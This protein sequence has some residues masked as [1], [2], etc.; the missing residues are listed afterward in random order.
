MENS[1]TESQ[2]NILV[3]VRDNAGKLP[4]TSGGNLAE[5]NLKRSVETLK[6]NGFLTPASRNGV[7]VSAKGIAALKAIEEADNTPE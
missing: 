5:L 7:I 1:I 6:A 4:K 3:H 2:K